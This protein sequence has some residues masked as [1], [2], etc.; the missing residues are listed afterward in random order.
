[1]TCGAPTIRVRAE[2]TNPGE[3]F[4]CCGLLEIADRLWQ[5][6]EAWFEAKHFCLRTAG[7]VSAILDVLIAQLPEEVTQLD[8]L[9]IK[10]LVAPLRLR[11][12]ETGGLTLDA[13][14]AVAVE[15]GEVKAV[16]N[17]PWNFWSGQQTSMR[18]WSALRDAL[19]VQ[20]KTFDAAAWHTLFDH[21]VLLSGRFGFDPGAAWNALDL[22]FSANEQKIEV[23][24]S[25]AVELLAAVG[26]QRFRPRVAADRKTFVYATWGQPL[27]APV[28]AAAAAGCISAGPISRYLGRV[29]SR[30]SYAALAYSN[31]FRGDLDE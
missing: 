11:I 3:F 20:R 8:K 1:M 29:V 18:I 9:S 7:T 13:W 19:T 5:G 21:R 31:P 30:G 17:P 10:R 23:A 27:A 25:P 15:K 4:A 26:L 28:A 22:G 12:G 16:A 24:S 2:P 6:T 14:M